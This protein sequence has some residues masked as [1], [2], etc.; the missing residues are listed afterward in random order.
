M[1]GKVA[2]TA[3]SNN[4]VGTY[5]FLTNGGTRSGMFS[6]IT[7]SGGV[8][9]TLV[10]LPHAVEFTTTRNFANV[11]L[12]NNQSQ[13]ANYLDKNQNNSSADFQTVLTQLGTLSSSSIPA[14]LQQLEGEVFGTAS[15]LGIQSTTYLYLLLRRTAGANARQSVC[16]RRLGR[17][18]RGR[19]VGR[20]GTPTRR[21]CW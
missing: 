5:T 6:G 8:R 16:E 9:A 14:A 15:E 7:I 3:A 21:S 20:R 17:A 12:T 4:D 18:R 1:G 19:A 2:V 13:V 11:A 10:Y